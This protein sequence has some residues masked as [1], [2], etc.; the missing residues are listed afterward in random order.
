MNRTG[1]SL[2]ITLAGIFAIGLGAVLWVVLFSS[3]ERSDGIAAYGGGVAE[4]LIVLLAAGVV[5]I[6]LSLLI[7]RLKRFLSS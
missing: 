5:I 6:R 4:G 2:I 3:R 7:L 1:T